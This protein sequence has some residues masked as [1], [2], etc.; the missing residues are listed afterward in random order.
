MPPCSTPPGHNC[1]HATPPPPLLPALQV[2]TVD[3]GRQALNYTMPPPA[4]PAG[5][6]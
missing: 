4:P 3:G 6:Q 1:L 5:K 2:I